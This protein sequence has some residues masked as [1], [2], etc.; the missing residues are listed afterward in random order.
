M[1]LGFPIDAVEE[2]LVLQP[3]MLLSAA[4]KAVLNWD[5]QMVPLIPLSQWLHFSRAPKVADTEAVPIINQ[6]TVLMVAQGNDLVGIEVER[7]WGEQ[8][9]TIRQV[10]GSIT[11]PPGF[12]GCTIL[13]DGRVVPLVDALGFMRWIDTH[14]QMPRPHLAQPN[15]LAE[16]GSAQTMHPAQATP[17]ASHKK[18]VMVVD[19]SIN[20]RRF[21]ALTL[22]KAGYRVE[23]AK[24]GQDALEKLEAGLPV[25]AVVCDIEMPRLDGYGFLAHVK[26]KPSCKHLPVVMLTSRSGEKHRQLAI[27]LGAK[28]YFS[29]PFREQE[30]LQTLDQL[31]RTHSSSKDALSQAQLITAT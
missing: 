4:G 25:Q 27:S 13:G 14:G 3:E 7:Y 26:S 1:L 11:M 9:V 8:E 19:D 30:L 16:L 28:A 12:T 29:K 23:Q 21:L 6:P 20:V 5:G 22:E 2:M 18:M 24:D 15:R 17:A 10:E 31:I